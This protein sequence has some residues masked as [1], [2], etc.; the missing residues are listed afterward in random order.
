VEERILGP[1]DLDSGTAH[2]GGESQATDA[3][4]GGCDGCL[5]RRAFLT[6]SALAAATAAFLAACGDG[7]I[8]GIAITDP[9]SST[10]ITVSAFPGLATA[11]TLV[12]ID[13]S[14]AVKRTGATTFV[15]FS[16]SCTHQ[17]FPVDLS[18]SGFL[19]NNHGSRFD[20]NG[21]VTLGPAALNLTELVTSY[22]AATDTLTI[23]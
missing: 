14:R 21:H 6:Q 18:G 16:R 4:F 10:T 1:I 11:G 23:G 13:G 5:T 22:D 20:N 7:Q 19:C 9:V 15:A 17:G 12:L 8:G 3:P 2:S